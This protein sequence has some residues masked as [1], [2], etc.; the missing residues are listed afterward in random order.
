MAE[1]GEASDLTPHPASTQ[2]LRGFNDMHR[3]P[4]GK[5]ERDP[6]MKAALDQAAMAAAIELMNASKVRVLCWLRIT[7]DFGGIGGVGK[8]GGEVRV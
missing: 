2:A 1:Q 3:T 8:C 5:A 4:A 7:M 6:N